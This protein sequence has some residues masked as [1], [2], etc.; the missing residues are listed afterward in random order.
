MSG[1]ESSSSSSSSSASSER[2]WAAIMDELKKTRAQVK[3]LK[4]K[5]SNK[6]GQHEKS[7]A[8]AIVCAKR[9]R[10]Q[11][12]SMEVLDVIRKQMRKVQNVTGCSTR[13]LNVTLQHLQPFLVGCVKIPKKKFVM[14]RIRAR[15]KTRLK[16]LLNGCIGCHKYVFGPDERTRSCPL[17][18][19]DRYKGG[20]TR[21]QRQPN[22]V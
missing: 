9:K 14:K 12:R 1:A 18:G 15:K 8:K 13:T 6:V 3:N 10:V 5:L 22:E 7:K 20:G 11:P 2:D 19:H 17:C 16:R 21:Q 4:G